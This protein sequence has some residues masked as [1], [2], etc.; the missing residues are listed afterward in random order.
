MKRQE[1][2]E[3]LFDLTGTFEAGPLS[4][5]ADLHAARSTLAGAV[6]SG[7]SAEKL[8]SGLPPA[9]AAL[10]R[11][12]LPSEPAVRAAYAR[13]I[14][15]EVVNKIKT[16][17]A[18]ATPR[19]AFLRSSAFHSNLD[20]T[21]P[22]WARGIEVTGSHGPFEIPGGQ[23]IWIDWFK[24][25]ELVSLTRGAN[26]TL[27]ALV[28][29]LVHHPQN[30]AR[31][32]HLGAGSVWI[33]ARQLDAHSPQ[34][35]FAG[36]KIKGGTLEFNTDI[37]LAN[38]IVS[39]P[40]Q[41]VCHAHFTLD[42]PAP[43]AVTQGAGVDATRATVN[44]PQSFHI[45][46]KHFGVKVTALADFD[47]SVYG[48]AIQFKYNGTSPVYNTL[49]KHIVLNASATPDEFSF[50]DDRSALFQGHGKSRIL[51]A[52]WAIPVAVTT[53][54]QLGEANGAGAIA[55]VNETGLSAS[56]AG[57]S[58]R[59]AFQSTLVYL[60]P[61]QICLLGMFEENRL[62]EV[63]Q[64]WQEA[65]IKGVAR[66]SSLE[67]QFA[68]GAP[69]Y[70]FS[71]SGTEALLTYSAVTA[72]IDRP[73]KVDGSRFPILSKDA[74]LGLLLN[75]AGLYFGAAG[76][77][78]ASQDEPA[79]AMALKNA[80]LKVRP[81]VALVLYGN[82][83]GDSMVKGTLMTGF[84]LLG[85][86]PILPDPYATNYKPRLLEDRP[87]G[88]LLGTIKWQS[89]SAP[90]MKLALI[91]NTSN[92]A[93]DGTSY[94]AMESEVK[95]TEERL[96]IGLL[97]VSSNADQLGVFMHSNI[98]P[99]EV[100]ID[101]L[102]LFAIGRSVGIFT[103]PEISWEPMVSYDPLPA[104][105]APHRLDSPNDGGAS[106]VRVET[107]KM[108]PLAPRPM[109]TMFIDQVNKGNPF[110]ARFTLPFGLVA[111][112]DGQKDFIS[113]GGRFE[114][115]QPE[116]SNKMTGGL[117]LMLKP[118]YADA[119]EK[120]KFQGTTTTFPFDANLTPDQ[121][122]GYGVDVLSQ[123][124]AIIF[125]GEF[126]PGVTT[127]GVPVRR[128][129]MSG[130][131]ASLFSDWRDEDAAGPSII[132]VCFDVPVGR[133]AYE[134]IEAQTI[135]Y[136]M[137]VRMV[138]TITIDRQKTAV[139][140]R[141]DSGWQ[142]ASPGE[143]KFPRQPSDTSQ[144]ED[145]D[146]NFDGRVH[147]G[148]VDGVYNVRNI[149]DN[150][151]TF[152]VD[153]VTYRP[154]LYD[155]DVG[156]NSDM[157][158]VSGG[159]SQGG[160]TYVACKDLVGY[161][162]LSGSDPTNHT[163]PVKVL[164]LMN[165]LTLK[166]PTGGRLSAV[167]D[168]GQSGQEMVVSLMDVSVDKFSLNPAF[169]AALRGTPILPRQGA[170]SVARRSGS[171]PAPSSLDPHYA[172]PLVRP[173]GDSTWHLAD[174]ADILDLAN[175]ANQYGL[176]QDTGTQ[177]LFF[178]QPQIQQGD[179]HI[180]FP[181]LPLLGDIGALLGATGIFPNL[182][183]ALK[184]DS[185]QPIQVGGGAFA[186]DQSWDIADP[187]KTL[188]DFGPVRMDLDYHDAK[189]PSNPPTKASISIQPTGW[190]VVLDRVTFK[191][192]ILP[193]GSDP[194]LSIVGKVQA[195]ST[196]APTF[197]E[198]D[199]IYGGFLS[200]VQEI[201]SKLQELATF[202][203]GGKGA[204]LD[205]SFSGGVLKVSDSYAIPNLPLGFGD[206]TD[207]ALYLGLTVSLAPLS[208][209]FSAG[210]GSEFKPFH[211]L[212]SPLSGTGVVQVGAKDGAMNVLIQAGIG[213]G[214]AI[215]VG[216]A[217]GSASITL[218]FQV[219]NRVAPFEVKVLLTGQA[220]V[221][222]LGGLASASLSLTAMLGIVPDLNLPPQELTILGGVAVGIHIS[223]CWVISI[224]FEGS[225]QFS[226]TFTMPL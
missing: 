131:G 92:Q 73:L 72:H 152:K 145:M 191:V 49:I 226:Q 13:P 126:G 116:F 81:P 133:T 14:L 64:L 3:L 27:V 114:L 112:V 23:P 19:Q 210:I 95:V 178:T 20:P 106:T 82:L 146:Y 21:L 111:H 222:V 59:A 62:R 85:L 165:L 90:H 22:D 38:D 121:Q 223:I 93:G 63:I 36:F 80:L 1:L 136:P 141:H 74:M 186:L 24:T 127:N 91:L 197:T 115:V 181:Q 160:R 142:P 138:R 31:L 206:I 47:A 77:M 187:T 209:D 144:P 32:L 17:S 217:S 207:V 54:A 177:K 119:L 192:Y 8:R 26:H 117:Q 4:T 135:L 104:S 130:Y 184:F 202:L 204:G 199:V 113:S 86:V 183:A 208:L 101:N 68:K 220:E 221:D 71:L 43:P 195:D 179:P 200:I 164:E 108:I 52:G 201:F 224:D 150:G 218:A 29:V 40:L 12:A 205:V 147:Q 161:A 128:Y 78:P 99:Q 124:V 28:P 102:A 37:T 176:L 215:D 6:L 214:L 70:Y 211:W 75:S 185:A 198:M 89:P 163:K 148:A 167:V 79:V 123:D 129:D 125:D 98:Q 159:F 189:D 11:T 58:G 155:A 57:L 216:I 16:A 140:V 69:L 55:F 97:D 56:W 168:I 190:S 30:T 9:L 15:N 46:F 151:A 65:P 51:Q 5:D 203:P 172:V 66:R 122:S 166:G 44:L 67:A 193:L 87:F 134:V 154:M 53:P 173:A 212:V 149:R 139:V 84:G 10:T 88:F 118:P 157:K 132:K 110:A 153:G 18:K 143:F 2:A 100:T 188:A 182:G 180:N 42:P 39:F 219:D 45:D 48:D 105:P 137:A 41:T 109:L 25:V 103:V 213:V 225:W 175:P 156:I 169:V 96:P 162:E 60:A 107:A 94:T 33:D 170:W 171:Q 120:S 83:Q 61:G 196:H 34:G 76:M 194:L 50:L 7:Q 174:P 158:V 35:G